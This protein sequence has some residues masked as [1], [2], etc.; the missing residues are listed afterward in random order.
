M[1]CFPWGGKVEWYS[2]EWSCDAQNVSL[3]GRASDVCKHWHVPHVLSFP[4]YL[5]GKC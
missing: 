2:A 4:P 1:T 3:I 5:I